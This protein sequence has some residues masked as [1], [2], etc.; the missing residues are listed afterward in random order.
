M[1]LQIGD[2]A[3]DFEAQTTEG[4][5]RFH[6]WLG[7][8]WGVLFSHPKDF[9]PVCT[10]EL[11]YMARIEPEFTK[12]NTKIIGLSID[13]VDN[14][15]KWA[16][17]IEETQG[18]APRYPMIGDTDLKVAKLYDML[19]AGAGETSEG[20]T[21]ADNATVRSVYVI[22]PDKKIK[23]VLTYPM[24]T[25]RNFDEILRAVDS[26]QL[27][28]KHQV[29][30]PANWKQ[31]E[32]VIITAAVSNEDAIKRFGAYETILPYLRKTKQPS[33]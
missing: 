6:E 5:V 25:G 14:H 31:G 4:R 33:A 29:A 13:P 11:G 10:T 16:K 27:T 26:M 3:P 7:G 28:A 15:S 24:T 20:R 21:P 32:D 23:L 22:G 9:T 2:I 17:D 12:R 18:T 30:T 1:A 8:A 19:P